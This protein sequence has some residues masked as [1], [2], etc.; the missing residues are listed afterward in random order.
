[1]NAEP[2]GKEHR[3]WNESWSCKGFLQA[4][5]LFLEGGALPEALNHHKS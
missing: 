5:S 2:N 4:Q 3:T 1:M